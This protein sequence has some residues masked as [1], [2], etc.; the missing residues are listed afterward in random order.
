MK[1]IINVMSKM[2]LLALLL[3]LGLSILAFKYKFKQLRNNK[4]KRVIILAIKDT[5]KILVKNNKFEWY[6]ILENIIRNF[7][8]EKVYVFYEIRG[9]VRLFLL[10][11][12]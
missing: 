4:N 12:L 2:N 8:W 9:I 7:K 3:I 1:E 10:E 11:L 6:Y 5:N